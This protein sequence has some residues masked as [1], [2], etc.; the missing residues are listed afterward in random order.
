MLWRVD[1]L[2]GEV[3]IFVSLIVS[4]LLKLTELLRIIG[5][6]SSW[7]MKKSFFLVLVVKDLFLTE[8]GTAGE[9]LLSSIGLLVLSLVILVESL[10][11]LRLPSREALLLESNVFFPIILELL[12][13]SVRLL[14]S[15][16]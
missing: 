5:F 2:L 6:K 9:R 7:V 8:S 16:A 14:L 15:L 1:S 10:V 4:I 13:W 12:L 11:L 3:G